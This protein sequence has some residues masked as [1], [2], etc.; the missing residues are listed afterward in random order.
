MSP[1]TARLAVLLAAA[2]FAAPATASDDSRPLPPASSLT[3][4]LDDAIA[5]AATRFPAA[6]IIEARIARHGSLWVYLVRTARGGTVRTLK[7]DA[8]TGAAIVN[9]REIAR[10][11]RLERIRAEVRRLA[12]FATTRLEAIQAAEAAVP[13]AKAYE[14]ELDDLNDLPV[15][16]VRLIDGA[17]RI[18][19][20]VSAGG[21]G[22]GGVVVPMPGD[23]V[24]DLGFDDAVGRAESLFPGWGVVKIELDDSLSRDDRTRS[25]TYNIR[26]A[27]ASGD[28]R[29]DIRLNAD[30]GSVLRD[31]VSPVS[32]GNADEFRAI[33]AADPAVSFGKAAMIAAES[34][35]G[36]RVHEIELDLEDQGLVY[37]VELI[38]A[39][40]TIA[41]V[42]V[43]PRTGGL[44][45]PAPQPGPSPAPGS[46]PITSAQAASIAMARVPGT[47]VREISLGT[48]EGQPVYEVSLV[49]SSGLRTD[50][51]V[52]IATGA[53][54]RVRP[55][56]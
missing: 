38:R 27:I 48:E 15:Y 45:T 25:A 13:G 46:T 3:I 39:D 49:D 44:V 34:I 19:V 28:Q 37:K 4:G 2:G 30:S 11:Q 18:V 20:I 23:G 26:L 7:F 14:V 55:R 51:K 33:V 42:R 29:R 5:T 10:G 21:N 32:G 35:P 36:S 53:V 47:T 22:T 50:V 56:T 17:R 12:T 9:K 24:P 43:D 54:L 8:G 40:G 41:L 31:R 1:L 6:K 16:K 52:A